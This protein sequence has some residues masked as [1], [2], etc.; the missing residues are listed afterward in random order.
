M[1]ITTARSQELA[2]WGQIDRDDRVLVTLEH[3]LCL[4]IGRIP[5]LHAAV[6]TSRDYVLAIRGHSDGED[7]ILVTDEGVY[8]HGISGLLSVDLILDWW[9]VTAVD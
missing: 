6:F 1:I 2:A 7:V 8:A 3:E 5:E 4:C 9:W